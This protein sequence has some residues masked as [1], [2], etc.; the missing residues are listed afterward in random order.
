MN[1]AVAVVG[2]LIIAAAVVAIGARDGRTARIGLLL[3]LALEPMIGDPLPSPAALGAREVGAILAVILLG[4]AMRQRGLGSRLGWP[5]E[6]FLALAAATGGL[7]L[8]LG[9]ADLAGV[10]GGVLSPAPDD[11][12]ARLSPAVVALTVG[13]PLLG[14]GVRHALSDEDPGRSASAWLL[15]IGGLV[16]IRTGLAGSPGDVEHLGVVALMVAVA[17]AAAAISASRPAQG[18]G[19]DTAIADDERPVPVVGR[20]SR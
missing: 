16:L 14:L 7:A 12:V 3:V 10:P 17:A 9:L 20:R 8:A 19:P 13:V 15:A 1:A 11:L 6:L 2:L 4:P 18:P 5:A